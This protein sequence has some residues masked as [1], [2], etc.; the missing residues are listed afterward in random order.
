[1]R[2]RKNTVFLVYLSALVAVYLGFS[3]W[4]LIRTRSDVRQ[5]LRRCDAVTS[6][7]D[8]VRVACSNLVLAVSA[9]RLGPVGGS[10][11]EGQGPPDASGSPDAP[12]SPGPIEDEPQCLGIGQNGLY[13]YADLQYSD[14]RVERHYTRLPPHLRRGSRSK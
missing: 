12:E 1:M 10:R 8:S 2:L 3:A 4:V 5:A 13:A 7:C 14:G 9:E 6:Y 11:S